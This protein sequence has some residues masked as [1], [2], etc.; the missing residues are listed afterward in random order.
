M[1][2]PCK[3]RAVVSVACRLPRLTFARR[4]CCGQFDNEM[5]EGPPLRGVAPASFRM[6]AASVAFLLKSGFDFNHCFRDGVPH[7]PHGVYR[8]MMAGANS[9]SEKLPKAPRSQHDDEKVAAL[10]LWLA[11]PAGAC[12]TL[13]RLPNGRQCWRTS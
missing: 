13:V 11:S 2:V 3:W 6:S 4:M 10:V 9:V 5:Q 8:E 7:V 12:F 1:P